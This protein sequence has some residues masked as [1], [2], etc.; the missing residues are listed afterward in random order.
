MVSSIS[1][2]HS[3]RQIAPQADD[4]EANVLIENETPFLNQI[5]FEQDHQEIEFRLGPLPVLAAETIKR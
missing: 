5:F 4:A 3:I 2:Q 1:F